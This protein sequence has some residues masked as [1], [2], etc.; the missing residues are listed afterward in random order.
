MTM[1]WRNGY[2][3]V[4]LRLA[5]ELANIHTQKV[6]CC[7]YRASQLE[8]FPLVDLRSLSCSH[9]Q[10]RAFVK[11]RQ[12]L[13]V[14]N[15]RSLDEK[16]SPPFIPRTR[17]I[18][19]TIE[20]SH[21]RSRLTQRC[22]RRQRSQRLRTKCIK[23]RTPPPF[24]QSITHNFQTKTPLSR[25]RQL[26]STLAIVRALQAEASTFLATWFGLVAF[27]ATV[28]A[29]CAAAAGF[30]VRAAVAALVVCVVRGLRMGGWH[31]RSLFKVCDSDFS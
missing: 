27:D 2:C 22:R 16:S 15:T 31:L 5:G 4:L 9:R 17:R 25:K 11:P 7:A 26:V 14:C 6:K 29:A 28:F 23:S 20:M 10:D 8:D 21:N 1:C 24:P 12:D 18:R 30:L 19:Q 3:L 13:Q